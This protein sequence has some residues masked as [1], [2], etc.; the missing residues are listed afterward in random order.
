MHGVVERRHVRVGAIVCGCLPRQAHAAVASTQLGLMLTGI[1]HRKG[2]RTMSGLVG[3]ESVSTACTGS[4]M[5]SVINLSDHGGS[6]SSAA[7]CRSC[8]AAT[9]E[10]GLGINGHSAGS[11]TTRFAELQTCSSAL[12][13][14]SSLHWLVAAYLANIVTQSSSVSLRTVCA[15]SSRLARRARY[16]SV[17]A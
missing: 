8:A 9:V 10:R 6:S 12:W 14:S 15:R 1:G 16:I 2:G 5:L 17:L 7:S 4:R 13:R 11:S 3:C